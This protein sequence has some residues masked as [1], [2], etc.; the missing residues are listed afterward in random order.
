MPPPPYELARADSEKPYAD[1]EA[2]RVLH[3]G[4]GKITQAI[5][6]VGKPREPG[7]PAA[8]SWP[9]VILVTGES[10]VPS[11]AAQVL[12]EAND[13]RHRIWVDIEKGWHAVDLGA[14]VLEAIRLRVGIAEPL[15]LGLTASSLRNAAEVEKM[16]KAQF[17]RLQRYSRRHFLIFISGRDRPG[18]KPEHTAI[19]AVSDVLS[20]LAAEE[21][22]T[23]VVLGWDDAVWT[24]AVASRCSKLLKLD[25]LLGKLP[26][27]TTVEKVLDCFRQLPEEQEKRRFARFLAVLSLFRRPCYLSVTNAWPLVA[28]SSETGELTPLP[29]DHFA[30]T[31][32]DHFPDKDQR[33]FD[34]VARGRAGPAQASY[35]DLLRSVGAIRDD[36]GQAVLMHRTVREELRRRLQAEHLLSDSGWDIQAHQGIA[37]WYLKLYRAS[38]DVA[39]AIESFH[40]RI[41][42]IRAARAHGSKCMWES[43]A[44][45]ARVTLRLMRPALSPPVLQSYL[46][47]HR[48]AEFCDDLDRL[49]QEINSPNLSRTAAEAREQLE[50]LHAQWEGTSKSG[51][52]E[53]SSDPG[54]L[55]RVEPL[56]EVRRLI[57]AREYQGAEAQI[58]Y[59]FKEISFT[60]AESL[61]EDRPWHGI[62]RYDQCRDQAREW[63]GLIG[64]DQAKLGKAVRILRRYHVLCLLRAEL[65]DRLAWDPLRQRALTCAEAIFVCATEIMR[66]I[67]DL[68]FVQNENAFLRANQGLAL[69]WMNR[70][71]EAHRRYN[72]A[73]GYLNQ[74]QTPPMSLRFA[75]IDARRTETFLC[76]VRRLATISDTQQGEMKMATQLQARGFL[77]D[78]I[79]A[80]ERASYKSVDQPYP[81]WH[82]YLAELTM[83]VCC[84]IAR[85]GSDAE[86]LYARARD[87]SG[88]G[89]WF[90]SCFEAGFHAVGAD[91]VRLRHYVKLADDFEV[92]SRVFGDDDTSGMH[93]SQDCLTR[94]AEL[95]RACVDRLVGITLP[96]DPEVC[97]YVDPATRTPPPVLV[98]RPGSPVPQAAASPS[99]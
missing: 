43:A 3:D 80:V 97:A 32:E 34:C 54:S 21:T 90:Y 40:H 10:G 98:P 36:G 70:P 82:S 15:L 68:R 6:D 72:E 27:K 65:Y 71:R 44:T 45:E 47:Q 39:A 55:L 29:K 12:L 77:Y 64:G 56:D 81:R 99:A 59:H 16:F 37:D 38:G 14:A 94:I 76:C 88:Y 58:Q 75:T 2:K 91:S 24:E 51:P 46:A 48:L 69:S 28:L 89:E 42:C 63:A 57:Y 67:D 31:T 22:V 17:G 78:A 83:E 5:A 61:R 7:K 33:R 19:T 73:Y 66:N 60:P 50:Q 13:P 87:R 1:D 52:A 74:L 18:K 11:A 30:E 86:E 41:E 35:L 96:K 23:T 85:Q 93:L 26:E 20:W 84:Q 4:V 9:R 25:P 95:K 79:G 53:R 62:V 49:C 92:A 8:D